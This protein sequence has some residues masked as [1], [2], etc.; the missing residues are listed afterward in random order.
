MGGVSQEKGNSIA[1]DNYGNVYITGF[2][3][4]TVDFDPGVGTTNLISKGYQDIFIQKLD[5]SGN[6]LWVKQ[7]GGASY[8]F[9]YSIIV[10]NIGNVY[11]TGN[12]EGITDFDPGVGVRNLTWN[13]GKDIFILKLGASTESIKENNVRC[14]MSNV[15]SRI[16]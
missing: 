6:L 14:I 13:G 8:D 16:S 11:S 3:E 9:G 12:F 10:D 15:K 4:Y 7:I 1:T 5:A 2:F